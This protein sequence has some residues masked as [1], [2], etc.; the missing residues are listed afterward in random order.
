M[1]R[2]SELISVGWRHFNSANQLLNEVPGIEQTGTVHFPKRQIRALIWA[3]YQ[4]AW[5]ET[6]DAGRHRSRLK[7]EGVKL[8]TPR[9]FKCESLHWTPNDWFWSSNTSASSN[10]NTIT[11]LSLAYNHMYNTFVCY[12]LR[13]F[14]NWNTAW[15]R[16]YTQRPVETTN[17]KMSGFQWH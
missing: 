9:S 7:R 11:I 6:G 8:T 14:E 15:H 1:Y 13:F 4:P 16:S 2:H 10:V 5:Y 3:W 17:V 12:F